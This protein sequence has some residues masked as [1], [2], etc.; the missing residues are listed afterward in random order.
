LEYLSVADDFVLPIDES[1]LVI[2]EVVPSEEQEVVLRFSKDMQI[3][4][5]LELFNNERRQAFEFRLDEEVIATSSTDDSDDDTT[6]DSD[7]TSETDGRVLQEEEAVDEDGE[8]TALDE[9]EEDVEVEYDPTLLEDW[10]VTGMTDREIYIKLNYPNLYS[11]SKNGF[12]SLKV[13][14]VDSTFLAS[15]QGERLSPQQDFNSTI[16]Q[17]FETGDKE[18]IGAIGSVA[19]T[20][21]FI[22][23]GLCLLLSLYSYSSTQPL[24]IHLGTIQYIAH[25]PLIAGAFPT[26][27]SYLMSKIVGFVNF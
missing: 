10:K 13:K 2:E 1:P 11:V 5:D 22:S 4:D 8:T 17:Q 25:F 21:L 18:S 3:V 16:P 6:D 23:S 26:N 7:E 24:W 12:S 27:I 19:V 9:G 20:V 14:V 15:T